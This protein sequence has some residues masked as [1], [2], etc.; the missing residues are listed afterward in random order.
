MAQSDN[1]EKIR[2]FPKAPATA[3]APVVEPV[4]PANDDASKSVPA[5]KRSRRSMILA[6][7]GLVAVVAAGWVGYE[8]FTTGRFMVVTDDAY[9]EGDIATISSK[10]AGYVAEVNVAANQKVKAGDPLVTL[11]H[12]RLDLRHHPPR[13]HEIDE[14]ENQRE[15]QELRQEDIG[16]LVKLGHRR[17]LGGGSPRRRLRVRSRRE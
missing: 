1:S 8:W 10:L 13:N 7:I 15:P 3:E 14:A 2:P 16:K 17:P 4:A 12:G 9:I 5:K 6:G 11:V